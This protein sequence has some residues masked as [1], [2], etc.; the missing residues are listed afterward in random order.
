VRGRAAGG[1]G[2]VR[3][4][5]SLI[6]DV[7]TGTMSLLFPERC[8]GCDRMDVSGLCP[9]CM[10]LL[11]WLRPELCC[12]RCGN[13]HITETDLGGDS[14]PDCRRH[15]PR[16]TKAAAVLQ[17]SGPLVRALILWKYHDYRHLSRMLARFPINWIARYSPSW[18]DSIEAI[19]PVPHHA[20]TLRQRG[21]NPPQEIAARIGRAFGIPVMPAV[22][23]K[24]RETRPQAGLHASERM[25]NLHGCMKV[26]DESLVSGRKILVIDDVMTTGATLN[27]SA[28]ALRD[29]GASRVYGLV[30]AR[31][32]A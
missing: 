10:E 5:D 31:Q 11:E 17:Y 16:Y 19:V 27:E 9:D 28:R 25:V 13:P 22:L 6:V 4:L 1:P 14:C 24:I 32:S 8:P 21:F 12:P 3:T 20:S 7:V 18:W 26:F 30:I 29:A 2:M 23:F 15:R